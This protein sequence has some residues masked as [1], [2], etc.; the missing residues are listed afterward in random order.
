MDN[1]DSVD[2]KNSRISIVEISSHF[3]ELRK[4]EMEMDEV[5]V[6][7]FVRF[8][9]VYVCVRFDANCPCSSFFRK[10][11]V[12]KNLDDSTSFS[13]KSIVAILESHV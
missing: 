9:Q 5:T 7:R 3:K 10:L 11:C 6:D 1:T 4:C 2:R 12:K 8:H 13:L